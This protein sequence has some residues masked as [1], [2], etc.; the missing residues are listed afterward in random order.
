QNA[1]ADR[2][3]NEAMDA[4]ARGEPWQ[5][6][7]VSTGTGGPGDVSRAEP[8]NVDADPYAEPEAGPRRTGSRARGHGLE[9]SRRKRPTSLLILWHGE[10]PLSVAKRFS[11]IGDPALTSNGMAQA[12]A[13]AARLSREPVDAIVSSPLKRARQTAEAVAV[14]TGLPV[15]VDDDLRETD[16]G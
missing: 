16:F 11:G 14:R 10:T 9:P 2:L 5:R 7:E 8:P 3:A 13:A 12:E 4:D 1:H 15:L 6:K